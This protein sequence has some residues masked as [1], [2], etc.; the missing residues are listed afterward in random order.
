M[1]L[2]ADDHRYIWHPFTQQ[3]GWAEED[4]VIIESAVGTT[5][6]DRP[7]AR[8]IALAMSSAP[9]RSGPVGR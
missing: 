3:Q 8:P 9:R 1:S 7:T 5:L 6:T 2:A 4:P